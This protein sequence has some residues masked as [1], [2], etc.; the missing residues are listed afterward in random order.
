[1]DNDKENYR[2][3][4]ELQ[5]QGRYKESLVLGYQIAHPAFRAGILIDAGLGIGKAAPVRE[6]LRLL[7]QILASD[8]HEFSRASVLYNI[9]NGYSNLYE[10]HLQ[11]T[12][13]LVP[14]NDDD[15]R[16]AK[17]AYRR[18]LKE[19]NGKSKQF[20]SELL[21]NYGTCL[22][23]MGRIVEA[24]DS[25]KSAL[26]SEP[27]NGMAAGNLGIWLEQI[28]WISGNYQHN[29]FLEARD[30]LSKALSPDMHLS[31]GGV[32]AKRDFQD[33]LNWL[34][35]MIA[36]HKDGIMPVKQVVLPSSKT[37]EGRYIRF[38]F[39]NN[40]FLNTCIGSQATAPAIA[41]EIAFGSITVRQSKIWR[42]DELLRLL[43]EIK[44]AFAT[45]RYL[46]FLAQ[47]ESTMIDSLSRLTSYFS[48]N[49]LDLHGL[50]IGLYKSAYMRAFDVLDKVAGIVHL[51][52]GLGKRDDKF[53][54]AFVVKQSRGQEHEI[55]SVCRPEVASK[56]NY[57][58][59]ALV[60]LCIDYFESEHVDFKV[61]DSRRN[62]MTHDYL[63]VPKAGVLNTELPDGEISLDEL[64]R[65]VLSVLKLAKH[66]IL[67]V[68]LSIR[69]AE[70]NK[71]TT[72]SHHL[73][74][75]IESSLGD[76]SRTIKLATF[77]YARGVA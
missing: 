46:F 47:S 13:S 59:F 55:R 17:K 77:S 30:Y 37:V 65:Q 3:A 61:I 19:D 14:T 16:M 22:L 60:D 74:G 32:E 67:Y 31:S 7:E 34:N 9:G 48:A 56:E 38:C 68:V 15:L 44:E 41:D 6:G 51:Y 24:I 11:K 21:V 2:S 66:A 75:E 70:E 73:S 62:R 5:K 42:V 72:S 40:L 20:R 52:F 8:Q 36:S 23:K 29:Y 58:L 4:I 53:W 43:N 18:A 76:S 10:I 63:A 27:S 26:N 45:A 71:Q 35:E 64:H 49:S 39:Q 25:F 1:M 28:A 50:Y 54:N 33:C 57:G 12:R 69:L